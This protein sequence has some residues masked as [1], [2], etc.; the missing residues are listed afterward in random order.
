MATENQKKS[1]QSASQTGDA[2]EKELQ[3]IID[4]ESEQGYRG[5]VADPTPN[6]AYSLGGV[7]AG[8]PTPETHEGQADK[9]AARARELGRRMEPTGRGE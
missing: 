9:A 8:E 4:K 5:V 7:A 2:G 1:D 3:A 6:S